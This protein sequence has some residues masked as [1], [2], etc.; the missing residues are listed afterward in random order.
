LHG[1]TMLVI[2]LGG[3]GTAISKRAQAFGMQVMAVDPKEME[4][5]AFVFSLH[6]PTQLMELLP[7]ADLVVLACPLTADTRGLIGEAQ[8][9]AMKKSAYLINIARGGIVQTPALV[10]ALE[11]KQIAGAGMDVTDPEPLPATHALRTMPNVV[12]SPHVGGQSADARDRQWRLLRENLRRFAAGE[13]LLC[14]VDKQ[15]GY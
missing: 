1:K 5:P 6:K 13:R 11:R 4:R 2:G 12:L 10:E 3:V 7:K 15:K 9:K 14:V 8:L